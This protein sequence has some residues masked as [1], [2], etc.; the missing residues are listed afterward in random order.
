MN[1]YYRLG[2]EECKD[3]ILGYICEHQ[4]CTMASLAYLYSNVDNQSLHRI[5][6][7]LCYCEKYYRILKSPVIPIYLPNVN[8]TA[9]PTSPTKSPLKS[10][11]Q[12]KNSR[13][14]RNSALLRNP[15]ELQHKNTY[16]DDLTEAMSLH[17]QS[18]T[19]AEISTASLTRD[20]LPEVLHQH[21]KFYAWYNCL[22]SK[23]SGL[24]R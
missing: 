17:Q 20:K 3:T 23:Y 21:L 16:S 24:E 18:I 13:Q 11:S 19:L 15:S 6:L 8:S 1:N 9:D 2:G 10:T 12:F 7:N 4:L 5:T 22:L 14:L